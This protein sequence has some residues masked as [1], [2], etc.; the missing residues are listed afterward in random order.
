MKQPLRRFAEERRKII[1]D[2]I[3]RLLAAGF[4]MEVLHPDWLANPVLVEKKKEEDPNIAKVWRMCIDYTNLNKACPKDPFPLPRIDQ[5]IDSTAGCQMLSFV[6]AYSGFHQIPLNPDDQIKTAFITPYGAYCYLTMPF[7]LRNAGA[8]Y[9][10]CMQK[11]LHSQ[12]GKNVQVYVDDIV[13]KTKESKT[14]IEDLRET[15]DNLRRYRMK[16]NPAKCTFGVPA[17]KLLGFLVSSRGIEANPTKIAAIER[18]K[19]PEGLKDVQ[20][21]TGCL[22][23]LSRFISRL[24][25]KALPLYQ[26]MKKAD[27]FTW[28]PE[29]DAAFRELKQMISTAPILASPLPKEPMLLYIA[30]TNR[31]VS[32][33]VVVEREEEGKLIQRPVYYLSE[34]LSTSKQNYPHYQK[35]TYGV[36]LAV[37]KLKHY[38]QE[39]LIKV[40][41]A[42]PIS[43]IM[44]NKD[45]SGRVAKWAIEV[46]PYALNYERRDAIKSQALADFLVDWAE[47]QY[48]PP[49]PCTNYWKMHFD[50]SR[51]K[52]GLGA[53]VVL[54]SPKLDVLQ[55][56][57]Q[58]HFAASNNVAEYEALV[59]G[60]KVAKEV[61]VR[62]IVCYG[63]SD[64]VVQQVSGNWDALDANMKSYRFHVQM[65]SGSFDGCEFH[66]V[67]RA[68]NEAADMLSKLGSSR[69]TIPAGIALEHLRKPSIKPSPE[70]PSIFIPPEPGSEAVPMDIDWGRTGDP[71]ASTSNPGTGL[72]N[73]GTGSSDPGT[74]PVNPGTAQPTS[75]EAMWL[76]AMLIDEPIFPVKPIPSWAEPIMSF[77]ARGELPE[78]E[79]AARQIQRRAKSYT[80]INN[81]LYKRSVTGVLQKCVEPE[82]G[83]EIL[84][85]IHQGECGHHDSSRA[86]V[87][88]AFRHGFYWPTAL[89]EAED[90]VRK[91]NGCQ[92]FAHKIHQPAS[93][94]KTIPITWPFAVWGLDMVGPFKPARGNLTHMLVFVDKFTKWIEVKPIKLC[95]G[96]TAVKFLKDIILRYGY[97]HSIITDNGTNFAGGAF[98]RFCME[99]KIRLDLAS[100]AHPWSNG[101]CE[102]ANGLVL[103]GIK[104]RLVEPLQRTPG[105]WIEELP[106][107]LWSLRT[108]PNRSTGY[109]P[110]F[111]VY[112]AE[113]VIP[114]DIEHDSPRVSLYTEKEAKEAR[115]NDVDLLDEARDQALER[116]AIYQQNL[117]RYHSQKVNPR[118]FREGDLVL[119]LVQRTAGMHKL[120]PPWDHEVPRVRARRA[121]HLRAALWQR[122]PGDGR[123]RQD[124]R[125]PGLRYR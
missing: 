79:V 59:H 38:F 83:R 89:A 10:R 62:R 8:T 104:P 76:E 77:L 72:Q 27:Q 45:A 29:A 56:V 121:S 13:I 25:E 23:S 114:A 42:A 35:M 111:L 94:L 34:V 85:D 71:G 84:L 54:T 46:A 53:G 82:E 52:D 33:V 122:S 112:G 74:A 64:L 95:D 2:E 6:D 19:L 15:F 107:V 18:M 37:K 39:H 3:A 97:P 88:K 60:L 4:I 81:Q 115:E 32:V 48:K 123:S 30:A 49:L 73:P 36:Y 119:R 91:C 24:G 9:Q 28:T 96:K 14:L 93:A 108:T 116:S 92:R 118:V 105:C 41:S 80:I 21:F 70:S 100:V 44:G 12:I 69:Q 31:V 22:A 124:G 120:S 117:R 55:Y 68:N 26:Q 110:F 40:V 11:C 66:H 75:A 125:R 47:M 58:I 67:G 90:L 63:D 78:Q 57:L 51:S 7:G 106:A 65:V 99:K 1:G 86:L 102:K 43:D 20:K 87:A 17:G 103:A 98:A 61:G 5:V 113:A 101:Q 50:G 109:T 16:L